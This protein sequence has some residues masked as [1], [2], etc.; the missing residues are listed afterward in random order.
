MRSL[1]RLHLAPPVTAEPSPWL[2]RSVEHRAALR[3]VDDALSAL[4]EA[5]P[6]DH[7]G[8]LL[9]GEVPASNLLTLGQAL[10]AAVTAAAGGGTRTLPDPG[11]RRLHTVADVAKRLVT[12]LRALAYAERHERDGWYGHLAGTLTEALDLTPT[13]AVRESVHA[14]HP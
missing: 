8:A 3:R 11:D 4:L 9:V 13:P 7:D 5:I 1:A 12:Q 2:V 10:D 6:R 14:R